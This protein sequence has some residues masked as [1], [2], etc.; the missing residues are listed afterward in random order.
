MSSTM[1]SAFL[2][3][4]VRDRDCIQSQFIGISSGFAVKSSI[5][6]KRS[7]QFLVSN[8]EDIENIVLLVLLRTTRITP[9]CPIRGSFPSNFC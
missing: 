6:R 2:H 1:G 7:T 4:V 3:H 5:V 8:E 9:H